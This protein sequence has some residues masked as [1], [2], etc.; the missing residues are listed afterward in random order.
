MHSILY[1]SKYTN[2]D[3]VWI[4]DV[5]TK[6]EIQAMSEYFDSKLDLMHDA[7][8]TKDLHKILPIG[9]NLNLDR[10]IKLIC[11]RVHL[12]IENLIGD[13]WFL[14][15]HPYGPHADA[16]EGDIAQYL[17]CVVPIRKSFAEECSMIV[18]DQVSKVGTL[19]I[20]GDSTVDYEEAN[21]YAGQDIDVDH[22][23]FSDCKTIGLGSSKYLHYLTDQNIS[24][25]L[26]N[27]LDNTASH[28]TRERFFGFTGKSY[29]WV[30]GD[31]IFFNSSQ[32]HC[33][34]K[35]PKDTNKLGITMLFKFD[36]VEECQSYKTNSKL[37]FKETYDA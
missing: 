30:P 16:P 5:L 15:G 25:D 11:D 21:E 14:T 9:P 34:G 32:M 3:V 6:E 33:S 37:N 17:H 8:G 20:S 28:H 12:P 36:T 29:N 19:T 4:K 24:D 22:P 2:Q 18:F 13:N 27:E 1:K 26:Y 31:I 7:Y 10:D 35:M 23:R